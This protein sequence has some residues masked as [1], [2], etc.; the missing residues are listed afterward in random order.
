MNLLVKCEQ[1]ALE[2]E[3]SFHRM[4]LLAPNRGAPRKVAGCD[5]FEGCALQMN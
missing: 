5:P 3:F 2:N 4:R 1:I